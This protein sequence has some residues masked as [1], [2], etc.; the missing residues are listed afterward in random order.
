MAVAC[1]LRSEPVWLFKLLVLAAQLYLAE[2]QSVI[3][4]VKLIHLIRMVAHRHQVPGLLHQSAPAQLQ[5]LAGIIQ[6]YLA[7]KLIT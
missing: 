5:H 7:L 1:H 6:W 4:T 2:Q 3:S